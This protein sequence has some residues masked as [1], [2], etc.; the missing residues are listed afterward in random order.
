MSS[1]SKYVVC[2][3]QIKFCVYEC[4]APANG[5]QNIVFS[6]SVDKKKRRSGAIHFSMSRLFKSLYMGFVKNRG[7]GDYA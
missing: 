5:L 6:R 7:Q 3:S 4:K 2:H 1:I